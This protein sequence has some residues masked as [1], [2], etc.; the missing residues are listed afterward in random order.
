VEK[1]WIGLV[2]FVPEGEPFGRTRLL[3]WRAFG[4]PVP[5]K[6]TVRLARASSATKRNRMLVRR[7]QLSLWTALDFSFLS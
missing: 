3:D 6:L 5:P 1:Q 4:F 7:C 2:R